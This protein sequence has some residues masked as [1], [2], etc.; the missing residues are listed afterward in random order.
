[1]RQAWIGAAALLLW[2]RLT[3]TRR[4]RAATDGRN[5]R[6]AL[7]LGVVVWLPSIA[8]LFVHHP[9]NLTQIVRWATSGTGDP[10]GFTEGATY[11]NLIA[12]A[13]GGFRRSTED[14]LV[15]GTGPA[16][17]LGIGLVLLLAV[18]AGALVWLALRRRRRTAEGPGAAPAESTDELSRRA[19]SAPISPEEKRLPMNRFS[20]I[21]RI[22]SLVIRK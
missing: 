14:L 13:P 19:G 4:V 18:I 2:P 8:E 3:H 10:I 7:G 16:T 12:P 6:W 22:S 17:V 5:H 21:Q 11:L 1:M 15:D 20:T 9:N